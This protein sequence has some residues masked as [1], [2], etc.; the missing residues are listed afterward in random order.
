MNS[1]RVKLLAAV[2]GGAAAAASMVVGVTYD[3]AGGHS[4][5]GGS[6]DSSS[7]GTYVQPTIP[8]MAFDPTT[9]SMGVTATAALPAST[10]ATEMAA[11][12]MKATAAATCVNNGQCP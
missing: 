4:L 10:L 12:T 6:G 9:M 1:K 8:Q 2:V 3:A 11:P 5:A 7:G